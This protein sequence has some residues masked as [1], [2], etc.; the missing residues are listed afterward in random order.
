[1]RSASILLL[2]IATLS[3]A[4][5][6]QNTVTIRNGKLSGAPAKDPSIIAFKGIPYAAPP[7][8][9]LRWRPPQPPASWTNVRDASAFAASCPQDIVTERKPW[10]AEFMTHNETNEDCLYLNVWT[11]ARFT[12]KKRPVFVWIHGGAFSEG[13][14]AVPVYDGQGLASKGLVVVTIN[15]RLGILGFFTYPELTKESPH[16]ASGNY[17]LLDQVAAL[18]W[19]RDNIAQFGGDPGNVT[20]AGQSA[21]ASSV[22]ALIAS[23]LARD[24]FQ[25]AIAESGLRVG[26]PMKSLKEQEEAGAHFAASKGFHTLAEL[27]AAK[28]EQIKAPTFTF[29]PVVDG[30][31][32][33]MDIDQIFSEGQQNDVPTLTGWTQDDIGVIS[34]PKTTLDSFKQMARQR[35]GKMAEP[36]LNV[37]PASNEEQARQAETE[38]S[39]DQMRVATFLWAV[40][41][42]KSSQT[43]VFTF[44]WNHALPGPDAAHFGAFHSSELPYVLNT[45]F[46]CDRPIKPN[47]S[48]IANMVSQY[49][50]NFAAKG[51]PNGKGLADWPDVRKEQPM[52]MQLGDD[53]GMIPVTATPERLDFWRHFLDVR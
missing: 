41:R 44:Y 28:P 39:R 38:S 9:E 40:K 2:T 16:H 32:L 46:T 49:W 23:P 27:R 17:G 52:T 26:R 50:A 30:Y 12:G 14:G 5:N 35:Y 13:S 42:N 25:R 7:V 36:F 53:S 3:A 47:D 8:G 45:L 43:P 21:G 34:N 6:T 33:P 31:L 1:M 10:T 18:H 15:Y 19:V 37:Y 20:I 11:Q 4:A 51:D 29:V 24:L 48:Q 22:Y